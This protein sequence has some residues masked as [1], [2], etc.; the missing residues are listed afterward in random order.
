MPRRYVT[1][2][3]AEPVIAALK[4]RAKREYRSVSTLVE[5]L[6]AEALNVDRGPVRTSTKEEAKMRLHITL[7]AGNLLAADSS[8]IDASEYAAWLIAQAKADGHELTVSI[9]DA[10]GAGRQFNDDEGADTCEELL[11]REVPQELWHN[12]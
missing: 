4:E 12:A 11:A 10:G 2:C 9:S 1:V 3:L 7:Y 8:Y 5:Q 6:L